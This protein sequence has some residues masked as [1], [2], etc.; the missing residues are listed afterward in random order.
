MA[1]ISR[2]DYLII[3]LSSQ[4]CTGSACLCLQPCMHDVQLN[5]KLDHCALI[6]RALITQ[7]RE[8]LPL[9]ERSRLLHVALM[10]QSDGQQAT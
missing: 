6:I 4:Y 5:S 7:S 8:P 10:C 3:A 9:E 1:I 2:L